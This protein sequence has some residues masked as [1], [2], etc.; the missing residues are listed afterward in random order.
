M[1]WDWLNNMRLDWASYSVVKVSM[2]LKSFWRSTPRS[3]SQALVLYLK[4]I[5]AHQS[6]KSD[7]RPQF[8]LSV[9]FVIKDLCVR[10]LLCYK[11]IYRA[12]TYYMSALLAL[13]SLLAFPAMYCIVGLLVNSMLHSKCTHICIIIIEGQELFRMV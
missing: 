7:T 11:Y 4:R 3:S 12:F 13:S 6:L 8:V 2:L 5:R 9:P 1:G 10:S